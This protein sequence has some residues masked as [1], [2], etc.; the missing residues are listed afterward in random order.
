MKALDRYGFCGHG[1]LNDVTGRAES[2]ASARWNLPGG[3]N[4]AQATASQSVER[5]GESVGEEQLLMGCRLDKTMCVKSP[6]MV[7]S[8]RLEMNWGL[9]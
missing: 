9:C 2:S 8:D 4:Q 6:L 1:V 5:G 3:S 7:F